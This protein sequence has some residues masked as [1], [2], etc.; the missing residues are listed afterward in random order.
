MSGLLGGLAAIEQDLRAI[1]SEAPP[2]PRWAQDWFP[3]L[4]AVMAYAMVR[5]HRPKRIVEVGSGHST[6]FLVRAVRDG[7]LDTAITA[8]DPAPRADLSKLDGITLRRETAQS[9]GGL[10]YQQLQP[11]DFLMIDSSHVLMPGTD[12]DLLFN[13]ILPTLPSGVF[14]HIH[15]IFLPE[16][17][18][19]E[20]EWRGYNE[21]LGVAPM[22]HGGSWTLLW[23]SHYARTALANAVAE[24]VAGELP[25]SRGAF[26]SSLWIEK[27]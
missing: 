1:G 14:V 8:V 25:L 22:L 17:Y 16:D 9:A 10:P 4:D 20:W 3:R 24:S 6:R 7:G 13:H 21:Q 26:E 27:A 11:G 19:P 15:D 18:P 5:T 12:V 2:Q 23:S